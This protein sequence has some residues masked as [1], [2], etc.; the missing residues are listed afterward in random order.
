MVLLPDSGFRYLSKIYN[1]EWMRQHGFL[2]ADRPVT[3]ATVL[4]TCK[5]PSEVL[6]IAADATVSDAVLQMAARGISQVPVVEDG[7]MVGSLTENLVLARLV[8]NPD[9]R[10]RLVRDVMSEPFPI[11]DRDTPLHE[12]ATMLHESRS[13]ALVRTEVEKRFE[14]LTRTDLIT[15]LART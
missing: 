12:I 4:E 15:A 9:D 5:E 7:A 1:D 13:A 3:A 14:I 10:N 2:D 11:V 8:K 6:Q